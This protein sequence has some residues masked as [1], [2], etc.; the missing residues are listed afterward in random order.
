MTD[1]DCG[2]PLALLA[3]EIEEIQLRA[4]EIL[5]GHATEMLNASNAEAGELRFLSNRLCE[6]LRDTLRVAESRGGRLPA[7][8]DNDEHSDG[9][10]QSEGTSG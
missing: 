7:V 8:V 5:L 6:A 9:Q 2:G 10:A 1:E 4:G 3:D